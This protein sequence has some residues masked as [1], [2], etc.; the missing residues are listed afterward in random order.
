MGRNLSLGAAVSSVH[1]SRCV[2]LAETIVGPTER[3]FNI[4]VTGAMH[5][6]TAGRRHFITQTSTDRHL[7]PSLRPT[8]SLF[9]SWRCCGVRPPFVTHNSHR[10][11]P[12]FPRLAGGRP[13]VDA[14]RVDYRRWSCRLRAAAA[15]M[16]NCRAAVAG[17]LQL[18]VRPPLLTTCQWR[19][20]ARSY[21]VLCPAT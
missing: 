8:S 9:S 15:A 20:Y 2:V 14:F 6:A 1:N 10:T 5:A 4:P 12:T 13:S 17:W 16:I 18:P 3:R 11:L 19:R 21:Q 7:P